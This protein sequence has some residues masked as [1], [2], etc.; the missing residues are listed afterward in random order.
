MA[1]ILV[2]KIYFKIRNL[3]NFNFEDQKTFIKE[4]LEEI[5]ILVD[6]LIFNEFI[7]HTSSDNEKYAVAIFDIQ[8]NANYSSIESKIK[9][10][11]M[12]E[13]FLIFISL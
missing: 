13:H 7:E 11:L 10:F 3:R 4:Y 2:M 1:L 12:H 5:D 6:G 8:K 9:D